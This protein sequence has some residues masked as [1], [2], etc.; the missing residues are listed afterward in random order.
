MSVRTQKP[1]KLSSFGHRFGHRSELPCTFDF[2]DVCSFCACYLLLLVHS[3]W[4]LLEPSFRAD[5]NLLD[6]WLQIQNFG[7]HVYQKSLFLC[8]PYR[9][10]EFHDSIK[11][12]CPCVT[13]LNGRRFWRG[14][15]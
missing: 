7:K 4:M 9:S 15:T 6:E 8:N 12:Q 3:F 10:L 14:L 1:R 11:Y 13:V 5:V 2:F